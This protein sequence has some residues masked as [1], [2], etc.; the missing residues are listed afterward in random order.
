MNVYAVGQLVRCSVAFVNGAGAAADPTTTSFRFRT[1]AGVL[2]T[3]TY[4]ADAQLVKDSTG[5]YHVDV[6][7]AAAGVWSWEFTGTGS[8]TA[9]MPSGEFEVRGSLL[10]A[11]RA[12]YATVADFRATW[13]VAPS[14]TNDARIEAA[15]A[16]ASGMIDMAVG[17][18]FGR[19]PATGTEQRTLDPRGGAR[20]C[21]H[22]GIVSLT[23]VE[24]R[25]SAGDAWTTLA[26][27]WALRPASPL[28]G[29]PSDHVIL[30]GS[31]AITEWP[32]G[33]ALVRI[34]G[35]FGWAAVPARI[36]SAT[37][38]LAHELYRAQGTNV[39]GI[40]GPDAL[41][42]G[43]MPRGLPESVYRLVDHYRRANMGC[44]V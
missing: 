24:Y 29:E 39:G 38:T 4:P 40:R 27:G 5:A 7:A 1:P 34:T 21:V 20:L 17:R 30:D 22:D 35:V 42:A 9:S 14:T 3:Y 31:G 37:A 13:D 25:T 18:G 2:T 6:T 32:K 15:L 23:T 16:E 8:V 19:Y 11:T 44:W 28:P 43:A 10:D 26:S 36:R 33:T 41:S 12:V